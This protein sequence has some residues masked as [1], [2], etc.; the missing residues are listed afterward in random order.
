MDLKKYTNNYKVR[1]QIAGFAY[2]DVA[3]VFD[4]SLLDETSATPNIYS[5]ATYLSHQDYK[6]PRQ[7]ISIFLHLADGYQ[8]FFGLYSRSLFGTDE[9]RSHADFSTQLSIQGQTEQQAFCI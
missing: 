6:A 1:L 4:R 5:A 8:E 7:T 3:N 2:H 9:V